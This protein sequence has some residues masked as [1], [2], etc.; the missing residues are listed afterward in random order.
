VLDG[1]QMASISRPASSLLT[2]SC[3]PGPVR[4]TLLL[5]TPIDAMH[6]EIQS[7]RG[8][9]RQGAVQEDGPVSELL[10]GRPLQRPVSPRPCRCATA[11]RYQP[12]AAAGEASLK[13][14]L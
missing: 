10:Q 8:C 12:G 2:K 6:P 9:L 13:I 1:H 3:A 7:L 11:G 5:V 4:H 14:I